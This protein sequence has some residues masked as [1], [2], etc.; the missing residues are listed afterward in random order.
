[1]KL[2]FKN[3]FSRFSFRLK[4]RQKFILIVVL[5]LMLVA[6]GTLTVLVRT[7]KLSFHADST[8][9]TVTVKG[10]VTDTNSKPLSGVTVTTG[11]WG[12][13]PVTATTDRKGNYITTKF[14]LD[15]ASDDQRSIGIQPT[16]TGYSYI[17][18]SGY[19]PKGITQKG[20]SAT[21][22]SQDIT[23]RANLI[24][25]LSVKTASSDLDELCGWAD[26]YGEAIENVLFCTP[27]SLKDKFLSKDYHDKIV[28]NAH[29]AAYI[30][31]Q[32]GLT[33]LPV[34]F[35]YNSD[36]PGFSGPNGQF[37]DSGVFIYKGIDANRSL[38]NLS[39]NSLDNELI[40]DHNIG[41][42]VDYNNGFTPTAA[43]G[44]TF[45]CKQI[46]A[47]DYRC[48]I[49][50]SRDFRETFEILSQTSPDWGYAQA[51]Y[52]N[53]ARDHLSLYAEIFASQIANTNNQDE[54]DNEPRIKLIFAITNF[55]FA[56]YTLPVGVNSTI[57]SSHWLQPQNAAMYAYK[58]VAKQ[59]KI[60]EVFP[61]IVKDTR[62]KT[63]IEMGLYMDEV[64][65]P[66]RVADHA[67]HGMSYIDVQFGN[68]YSG[69][70]Q[71]CYL[72]HGKEG[73]YSDKFSLIEPS[74]FDTKGTIIATYPSVGEYKIDIPKIPDYKGAYFVPYNEQLVYRG[75]M[76][77][78][79]LKFDLYE[80]GPFS[81]ETWAG[82]GMKTSP[83]TVG[84]T[85]IVAIDNNPNLNI[86]PVVKDQMSLYPDLGTTN[87]VVDKIG[88]KLTWI[89]GNAK[90][91]P[92]TE[93]YQL[94]GSTLHVRGNSIG[95]D[96]T[97]IYI[98]PKS[99]VKNA[100]C[101]QV[102]QPPATVAPTVNL[103]INGQ[104]AI[105]VVK[106]STANLTWVTTNAKS[107]TASG[108]WSGNKVTNSN[109]TP[110]GKL[111]QS[112]SYTLSCK[113]DGGTATDTVKVDVTMCPKG[114]NWDG[115]KCVFPPCPAG[116]YCAF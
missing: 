29:Q 25:T 86:R 98:L 12:G 112:K 76:N 17:D 93:T 16:K 32:V 40:L 80:S 18:S 4:V 71:E 74:P 24:T 105:S 43:D 73:C 77:V 90:G 67:G 61:G 30:K 109:G 47:N 94:G 27:N 8:L 46:S 1:M 110:T 42:F 34:I 50:M 88:G 49:S 58:F 102:V 69:K 97:G 116:Q 64:I 37:E 95:C 115:K 99:G 21:V 104:K 22:I 91:L 51:F 65:V 20:P 108:G 85:G 107:C 81:I 57:K 55:Q 92:Q 28:A 7:G 59:A 14:Y 15:T 84:T 114:W 38:I 66:I 54:F 101:G 89:V 96:N 23:M 11:Y 63:S 48:P 75:N 36:W 6:A 41:H 70:T 72:I 82:G 31:T 10:K 53:A 78:L 103:L 87:G 68:G 19:I 13:K 83:E 100:T 44:F 26:S 3:L 111:T 106:N 39:Y 60:S 62:S 33:A 52:G 35:I 45:G 56:S 2:F 9:K 5:A 79:E 113:G